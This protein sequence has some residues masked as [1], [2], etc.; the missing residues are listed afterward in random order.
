MSDLEH[1]TASNED[2]FYISLNNLF[3]VG[4]EVVR[5]ILRDWN[6]TFLAGIPPSNYIGD[7]FGSLGGQPD[8]GLG[9]ITGGLPV[10]PA[11]DDLSCG[12]IVSRT[13]AKSYF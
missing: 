13:A 5:G 1:L 8:F 12:C 11:D 9:S 7:V 4:I 10:A 3:N 6:C 2:G